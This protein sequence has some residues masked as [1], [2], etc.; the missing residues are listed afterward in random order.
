MIFITRRE[1]WPLRFMIRVNRVGRSYWNPLTGLGS[2]IIGVIFD[3]NHRMKT[4]SCE[5]GDP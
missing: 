4:I 1:K 3:S 5:A 2:C